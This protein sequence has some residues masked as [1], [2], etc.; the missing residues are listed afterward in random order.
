MTQPSGMMVVDYLGKPGLGE[1]YYLPIE[2][3]FFEI[4]FPAIFE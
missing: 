2:F 4:I 3:D 1:A